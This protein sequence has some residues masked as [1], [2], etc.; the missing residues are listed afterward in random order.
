[1]N[2]QQLREAFPADQFE[3]LQVLVPIPRHI[4]DAWSEELREA[5]QQKAAA[6]VTAI[7]VAEEDGGHN[8]P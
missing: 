4:F 5:I 3:F 1:M 7:L 8:L 2:E 6:A